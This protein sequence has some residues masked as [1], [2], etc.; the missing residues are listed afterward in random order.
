MNNKIVLTLVIGI[1]S[2]FMVVDACTIG[3]ASG[4]VTENGKPLI[5][6]TRDRASRPHNQVYY[7]TNFEINFV[8][9]VD[10]TETICWMGLNDQGFAVLN[11][12]A[13]DLDETRDNNHGYMMQHAL[14]NFSTIQEFENY[15]IATNGDREAWGNFAVMDSAGK[16][17]LFEVSNSQYWRYDADNSQNG[18]LV[19]TNFS[20]SGGGDVGLD[21]YLRSEDI[22]SELVENHELSAKSLFEYNLRDLSDPESN[23]VE[24]PFEGHSQNN[25]L[26][27]FFDTRNSITDKSSV[28]GVVMQGV[29]PGEDPRLSVMYT[30]LGNPLFTPA[31]PVFPIGQPSSF[32]YNEN[33]H[34]LF[35]TKSLEF[36]EIFY[37][38]STSYLLDTFC[39]AS[40]NN[41]FLNEILE[42]EEDVF[43]D[44]EELIEQFNLI[45]FSD[46]DLIEFQEDIY[47]QVYSEYHALEID[48]S[49][50]PDFSIASTQDY[51]S[52]IT[53]QFRNDTIHNPPLYEWDFNNDGTTDSEMMNPSWNFPEAGFYNITLKTIKDG[54]VYSTSK[55]IYL[56][57]IVSAEEELESETYLEIKPMQNPFI[58]NSDSKQNFQI[59]FSVAKESIVRIEVYNVKGEK[60]KN[61]ANK[62][63]L[64]GSYKVDWNL[65]NGAGKRSSSGIY[66]FSFSTDY[67]TQ[68]KRSVIY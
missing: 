45:D 42:L 19:R 3:I 62:H 41:D 53:V 44:T 1:I 56:E 49:P 2:L 68:F 18:W 46:S 10:T 40:E 59:K 66:I 28:S 22:I 21:R 17:S 5:W 26:Y 51:Y 48:T 64:P 67:S 14:G 11:S 61:L 6:K 25:G 20:E 23:E 9:V 24:I 43:E 58:R 52:G 4:S 7:N 30:A 33:G 27:G 12:A 15:L 37:S 57:P 47:A 63:Y 36:K 38:S 34:A 13:Y 54:N 39:L 29:N 32:L 65:K 31:V 50:Q 8:S 35:N 16:V 60:I 55:Q